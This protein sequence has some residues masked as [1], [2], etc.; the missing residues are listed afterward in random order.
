MC[1]G[2]SFQGRAQTSV[3]E[4]KRLCTEGDFFYTKALP[5]CLNNSSLEKKRPSVWQHH[6]GVTISSHLRSQNFTNFQ[7]NIQWLSFKL[8]KKVTTS[9]SWWNVYLE[10]H[11]QNE[12]LAIVKCDQ[13]SV[14]WHSVA[15]HG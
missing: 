10:P 13:L 3:K 15:L 2:F 5:A 12:L 14:S 8:K 1:V 9:K 6:W 11:K 7:A 4:N